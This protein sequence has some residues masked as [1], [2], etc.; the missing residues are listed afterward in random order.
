MDTKD[1]PQRSPDAR[2]DEPSTT[3]EKDEALDRV[4]VEG[5]PRLY[6]STPDLLATGV[7][8]GIEVGIGV[9]ALLVVVHETD[10]ML[11][12]ALAF[13]VGFIALRLG[14]SELFTES[15]HVPVMVVVAGEARWTHLLRLWGGT[16][17]GNLV[18]GWVLA[19][20]VAVSLPDLHSTAGAL[21]REL[22]DRPLDLGTFALAVL[23]GA[24]ITLLTRMQSGTED[25]MAKVVA[26][27][28]I[29][30]VIVGTGLLHSVLDTLITFVAVHAGEPGA[31][32]AAWLPWFGWV[33]LGN[34]VGGLLLT[35][36]L[37]VVRSRERLEQWRSAD[38]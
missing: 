6:R 10:S 28:A 12:G 26:A 23:A 22:I 31:S 38:T 4:I 13:S 5:T 30:F 21:N 27:V 8:A 20:L 35:T 18:G 33:V 36:L 19:W 17:L 9:L 29:A 7:V 32:L 16:L 15:F 2:E 1:D 24:A 11:L 3:E 14:H 25:D 34:L 37:R